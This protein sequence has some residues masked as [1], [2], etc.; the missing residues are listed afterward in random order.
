MWVNLVT[1][2]PPATALGFNP[3][4]MNVM[5][6]HPRKKNETLISTWSYVRY[7]VV[8]LYVGFAVV[9]IFVYWYC[10]DQ[11]ADGHTLVT[12]KQL[13]G[14]GDCKNWKD[15]ATPTPY[16]GMSFEA[17][18]CSYFSV[19]KVKASTLSLT[20]LVVIEML[21][22]YNAIS[23]DGSL[24][25]MPPWV[26]PWLLLMTAFSIGVHMVILYIPLLA[27]IFGVVPLDLHDWLMVLAFSSPV[28]LIDEVLKFFG[29]QYLSKQQASV[30]KE[31]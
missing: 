22:A 8:G 1:D 24:Y 12:L 4:D 28:I 27:T 2:G 23:E 18:K 10:F 29:R 30:N 20:V 25:H 26:N 21:N 5:Q 17:E 31:D 14:W 15:F 6:K 3:P 13:M 7:L 11:A 19:G 9:G 16:M